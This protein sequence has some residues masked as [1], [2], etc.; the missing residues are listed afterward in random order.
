MYIIKLFMYINRDKC[1]KASLAPIILM[2]A[3][4]C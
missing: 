4:E 3:T 2:H 1:Q